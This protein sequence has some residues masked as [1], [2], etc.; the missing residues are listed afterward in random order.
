MVRNQVAGTARFF[1]FIKD[2]N[3][4]TELRQSDRC[5]QSGRACADDQCL[6]AIGFGFGKN[7][8]LAQFPGFFD[9]GRLHGRDLDGCVKILSGTGLLAMVIRTD[10]SADPAQRIASQNYGSRSFVI[11]RHA[12]GGSHDE[13]SR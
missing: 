2:I 12:P 13:I 10:S 4:P 1:V 3:L 8:H 9:D 5:S 6:S 7:R 11:L